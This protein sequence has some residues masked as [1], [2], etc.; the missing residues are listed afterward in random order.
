M[1]LENKSGA[2]KSQAKTQ[3]R[4]PL[5]FSLQILYI[6]NMFK[7][8]ITYLKSLFEKQKTFVE[9]VSE[10]GK[11][12]LDFIHKKPKHF[13]GVPFTTGIKLAGS[14]LIFQQ[15]VKEAILSMEH[16]NNVFPM[17]YSLAQIATS[18]GF[19]LYLYL[20]KEYPEIDLSTFV[21]EDNIYYTK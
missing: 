15:E 3:S 19:R 1:L 13:F 4:C 7:S 21:L 11:V 8:I 14:P 12:R 5:D 2:C 18:K 10:K 6:C 20:D 17:I 9:N 16:K